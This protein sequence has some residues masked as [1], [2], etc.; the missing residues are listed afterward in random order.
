MQNR[1]FLVDSPGRRDR[2]TKTGRMV[3]LPEINS[4]LDERKY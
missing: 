1:E 4:L 2:A 3:C